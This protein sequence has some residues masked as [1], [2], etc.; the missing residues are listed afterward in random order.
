MSQGAFVAVSGMAAVTL[1][2][3]IFKPVNRRIALLAA[4]FNFGGLTFEALRLNPSVARP[5]SCD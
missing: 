3:A 1:S 5:S 4:F 2:Y